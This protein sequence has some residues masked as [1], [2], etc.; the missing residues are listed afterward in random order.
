MIPCSRKTGN[1]VTRHSPAQHMGHM[2]N[3][4]LARKS[5]S[6]VEIDCR[7][8]YGKCSPGS[9]IGKINNALLN[10]FLPKTLIDR[11]CSPGMFVSFAFLR[12][13]LPYPKCLL[14]SNG[15]QTLIWPM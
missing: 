7:A 2:G 13:T 3:Q 11:H 4:C 10:Y 8:V 6:F 5:F 15:G 1:S 14:V 12:F 9:R